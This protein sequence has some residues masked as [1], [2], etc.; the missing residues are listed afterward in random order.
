MKI[1]KKQKLKRELLIQ[2]I[3]KNLVHFDKLTNLKELIKSESKSISEKTKEMQALK[4][5]NT[6]QTKEIDSILNNNINDVTV[7]KIEAQIQKQKMRY[8]EAQWGL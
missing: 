5:I 1:V 4:R 7:E 6:I 8:K 3:Y 2:Q